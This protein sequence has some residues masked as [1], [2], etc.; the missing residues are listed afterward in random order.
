[1]PPRNPPAKKARSDGRRKVQT[2]GPNPTAKRVRCYTRAWK[3]A[4]FLREQ[5]PATFTRDENAQGFGTGVPLETLQVLHRMRF[6]SPE[7]QARSDLVE[8]LRRHAIPKP[9][10]WQP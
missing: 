9:E 4:R 3:N 2:P 7:L 5:D 1:M 8:F 6:D 10:R